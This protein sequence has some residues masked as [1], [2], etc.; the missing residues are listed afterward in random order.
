MKKALGETQ[1]LRAGCSK[2]EQKIFAPLETPFV[3]VQDGQNLISWRWSLP[4]LTTQFGE[5]QCMQFRVI[6]V[7]DPQTHTP[8]HI[9]PQTNPQTGPITIH[10]TTAS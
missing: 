5:D 4:S 7:T 9:H 6:V 2:V 8:T 10:C 1:T 3:G